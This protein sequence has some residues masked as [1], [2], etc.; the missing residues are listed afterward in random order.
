MNLEQ[1]ARTFAIA[2]HGAI[3]HQRKYG[4]GPYIQH[5]AEVVGILRGIPNVSEEMLAAGW[6]HDVV[7]DT[8]ITIEIIQAE[9]G[10]AV[11]ALVDDLTDV[12]FPED[13]NRAQRK[14]LDRAHT[15][16]ISPQAKT[17]KLAD[18]ISNTSSIV[19]HDPDFA[20]IY[21]AEKVALLEVM[22]EGDPMLWKQAWELTASVRPP[23]LPLV[24]V[25]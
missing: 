20:K 12:S 24:F 14:A 10:D 1:K 13:G 25:G 22:R 9:F 17:V 6:L 19:E 5:P 2:A 3:G 8:K 11:A 21:L 15:A 23:S 7:E 4:L 16:L 18:L